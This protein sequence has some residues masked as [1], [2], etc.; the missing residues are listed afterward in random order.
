MSR[1]SSAPLDGDVEG[2]MSTFSS[3]LACTPL[4]L[5]P[6]SPL[7]SWARYNPHEVRRQ[8]G[9]EQGVPSEKPMVFDHEHSVTPFILQT[10]CSHLNKISL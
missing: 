5:F 7:G 4:W 10:G 1:F 3:L 6:C 9:Y 2:D 8:F